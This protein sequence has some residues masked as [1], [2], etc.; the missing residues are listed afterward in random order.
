MLTYFRASS[1]HMS[2]YSSL[3]GRGVY[4]GNTFAALHA[5]ILK[6][7]FITGAYT[8]EWGGVDIWKHF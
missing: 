1:S 7:V 6:G 3:W 4:I 8:A 5:N 2:V